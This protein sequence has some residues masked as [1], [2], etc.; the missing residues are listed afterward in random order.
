M[1]RALYMGDVMLRITIHEDEKVCRLELAGRLEGP[2]VAETENAWCASLRP[3][4][5]IEVD[6]RQLTGVDNAGRDLLAAIHLAGACL[7]VEGVWLTTL[8]G[9]VTS[10]P[11]SDAM[12]QSSRKR[13][14]RRGTPRQ[15]ENSK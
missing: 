15:Q 14:P 3:E 9:E 10:Q 5:K 12:V 8:I 11:C 1:P 2:W 4:R 6:L 7:I 13:V